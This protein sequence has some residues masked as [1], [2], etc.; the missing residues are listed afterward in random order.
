MNKY[1]MLSAAAFL[2]STGAHAG[3]LLYSFQFGTAGGGSYCD[4]GT[5]YSNGLPIMSWQH[6]N[7]NCSGGVSYGMGSAAKFAGLKGKYALMSDSY[8][9]QSYGIF[10]EYLGYLL[11]EKLKCSKSIWELWVGLS[12]TT[13]FEVNSGPLHCVDTPARKGNGK[14]TAVG[15]KEFIA[16][17]KAGSHPR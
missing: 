4:G 14:S 7:N 17:H 5:V 13:A 16:V 15:L 6:T 10:S 11:P 3:T 12:G 8:F 2:A 9:A 1:L